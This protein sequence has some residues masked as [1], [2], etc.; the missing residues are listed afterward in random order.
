[1]QL[2]FYFTQFNK[3]KHEMSNAAFDYRKIQD[4]DPTSAR[5]EAWQGT[6]MFSRPY[7]IEYSL[8]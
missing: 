1:M 3:K 8:E 6:E 5:R 4:G 2:Y 7:T